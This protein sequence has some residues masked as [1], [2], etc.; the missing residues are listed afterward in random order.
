M[1]ALPL[2]GVW[3]DPKHSVQNGPGDLGLVISP[4]DLLLTCLKMGTQLKLS[5]YQDCKVGPVGFLG[6]GPC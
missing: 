2:L 6:S 3:S 5:P 4:R 1:L